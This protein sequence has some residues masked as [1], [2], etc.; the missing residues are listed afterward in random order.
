MNKR[1]LIVSQ[2]FAPQNKIG[3]V[4]PTKLTKY[5]LRMGYEVTVL[6]GKD[7]LSV[8]DPLLAR[9]LSQMTDV[10][11]VR[12]HSMLRWWKEREKPSASS[13]KPVKQKAGAEKA[14]PLLNALY[15]Y[16][17]DRADAAFARAC[18]REVKRMGRQYD[19]VLSTYGPLSV[20]TI[21]CKIKRLGL[22][23]KW[24][25][26][27]RDE[28]ATPFTWQKL[29]LK[30]YDRMVVRHA[31]RITS[32]SSGYLRV[33]GLEDKGTCIYNGFDPEDMEGFVSPTKRQDKLSF[34]HCGQ[35][36]GLQRDLSPFFGALS[37]LIREGE[38]DAG[39]VALVYAG[40]DTRGFVK[41]AS[42]AGLEACL[43]GYS[44]MP[45]DVALKL[46]KS[47]HVLLLPAWNL[48][49]RQGNIPGKLLEYMMLNMPVICCVS[50][51]IPESEIAGIMRSTNIGICYEHANRQED[52]P[53]LK[54]YIRA[55]IRAFRTGEP[56]PFT[57]N[58]ET[59]NGFTCEGMARKMA[60]IMEEWK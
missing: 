28:V 12:E 38:I 44:F 42:D 8:C 43:E 56:M 30:R 16:L 48:Q 9:D 24:I 55:A 50:G 60:N 13:G 33:M 37:E 25:A 14:R 2:C 40:R 45:R 35:M 23:S 36:Y 32:V 4:R 7:L 5:L 10:H 22:A 21:A 34:I 57:P 18:I 49:N 46:Q 58:R 17:A 20:H 3:A 27:F 54:A 39:S 11:F 19:V 31:D 53:R 6:C 29:R 41:Q 52:A 47:S 26:D 51:E 1:I 15:L 59:V